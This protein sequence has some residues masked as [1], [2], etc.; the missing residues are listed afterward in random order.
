M[1]KWYQVVV[2]IIISS[3]VAVPTVYLNYQKTIKFLM[4][5]KSHM[6]NSTFHM[7]ERGMWYNFA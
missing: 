1:K 3:E 2:F 4:R 5:T 7:K 6:E